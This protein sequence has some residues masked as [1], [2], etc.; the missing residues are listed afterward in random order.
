M[1]WIPAIIATQSRLEAGEGKNES[2]G[3]LQY[4][5]CVDAHAFYPHPNPAPKKGVPI[6]ASVISVRPSIVPAKGPQFPVTFAVTQQN[7]LITGRSA[8]GLFNVH[9]RCEIESRSSWL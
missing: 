5:K 6:P 4:L 1:R 3:P 2:G 7:L 8:Y 9:V